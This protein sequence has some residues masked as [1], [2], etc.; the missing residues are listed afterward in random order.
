M[1]RGAYV[2]VAFVYL[3]LAAAFLLA[4]ALV[5]REFQDFDWL[6]I[7]LMHSHLFLFFPLFGLLVLAAFYLPSVAFTHM[8][9]HHVPWG[10]VRFIFGFCVA[11][12]VSL[13]VA[14]QLGSGGPRG[15][16]EISPAAIKAD[17]GMPANCNTTGVPCERAPITAVLSKLR[18]AGPSRMGLSEFARICKQDDLLPASPTFAEERYCF[19]ALRKL[20]GAEC[21][22]VQEHFKAAVGALRDDPRTRSE[23]SDLDSIFLPIKVFF[24][25]VMIFVAIMLAFWR[26]KIDHLYRRHVPAIERGIM[27]GAIAMLFW[28]IMDYGYQQTADVLFGRNYA[29]FNWRWSLVIGPWVVLLLFFFLRRFGKNFAMVGQ[30]GGIAGGLFAVLRYQDI[31]NW[32]Q[33]FFGSGANSWML[34]LFAFIALVGLVALLWP[35]K[36]IKPKLPADPA[37][38]PGGASASPGSSNALGPL[39]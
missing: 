20:S 8:Y 19:P 18:E 37:P 29:S 9:W 30:M 2:F 38:A 12:G 13:W 6:S 15:I 23:A 1:T 4:T 17:R 3:A 5:I 21:C 16:W 25:T 35:Q 26:N 39:T 10:R 28:P 34:F 27:I 14:E 24:I 33:R 36:I 7:I 11:I 31:N 22:R 32:S